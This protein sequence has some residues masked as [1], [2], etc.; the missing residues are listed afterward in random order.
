MGIRVT[1]GDLSR[2]AT[3]VALFALLAGAG[4][5]GGAASRLDQP[6]AMVR[7][8]LGNGRVSSEP[9][10][11]Y[12]YSCR[13]TFDGRGAHGGP[14]ITGAVWN[15]AAKPTV[16]GSVDWPNARISIALEGGK[17]VVRANNLPLHPTGVLPI[18]P[19]DS[20]FKYDRNP[21]GIR[22]QNVL[23]SLPP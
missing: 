3:A 10:V 18:R 2:I 4:C 7:L 9:R 1:K 14:W 22:E 6:A 16:G 20:V 8:P 23:L 21:N 11:G 13:M 17:R 19:T 15:P 5:R 12:V